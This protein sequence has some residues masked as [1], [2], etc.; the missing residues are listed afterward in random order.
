VTS[1]CCVWVA[2]LSPSCTVCVCAQ[3]PAEGLALY[4]EGALKGRNLLEPFYRLHAGRLKTLLPHPTTA[5]VLRAASAC[6]F[7][8]ETAAAAATVVDWGAVAAD[9]A[10]SE[11]WVRRLYDDGVAAL[12]H[13]LNGLD[14]R[15]YYHKVGDPEP[16][17]WPC[18]WSDVWAR[19]RLR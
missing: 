12:E 4:A 1:A 14:H 15:M 8:G 5:E 19:L 13:C 16:F 10:E 6:C 7:S 9:Q 2:L 11:A 18:K 3:P 17:S